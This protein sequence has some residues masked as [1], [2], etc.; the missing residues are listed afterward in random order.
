MRGQLI[1]SIII[2]IAR[3]GMRKLKEILS[4]STPTKVL[5]EE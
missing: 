5:S 2:D 4:L 3:Q 1:S